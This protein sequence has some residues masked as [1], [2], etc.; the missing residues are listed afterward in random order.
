MISYW[1]VLLGLAFVE[2]VLAA[3]L[4]SIVWR[5]RRLG[6]VGVRLAGIG[7]IFVLQTLVSLWAY[8]F[9]MSEGYGRDV[10]G[11]LIVYHVL[12][13]AGL[14]LLLDIVRK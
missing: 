7:L 11:P 12:I 2:A 10:A 3:W 9:W 6:P 13:L 4:F 5:T 1:F 8:V 14:A